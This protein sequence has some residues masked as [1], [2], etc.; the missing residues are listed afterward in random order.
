M[1]DDLAKM[2]ANLSLTEEE[3]VEWEAL[4]GEWQDV[5]SW[6]QLCVVGKLIAD[7]VS[8]ETIKT[9]L[10]RWWKPLGTLS[11][12]VLGENVFLIEFTDGDDKKWILE[13][14][15]WVFEGSLFLIVDFDGHSSPAN[16]TF[17]KAAFWV[18]MKNL[19]LACIGKE[20]GRMLGASAGEVEVVDTDGKGVGWGEYLRVKI[21]MDLSKPLAWGRMLKLQGKTSWIPFQYERLPKFCFHC[22]VI[23]HGQM[24]CPGR[25][26]LRQKESST[27]FGPWL[28][29]PSP[30]RRQERGLGRFGRRKG[31]SDF[32]S[33]GT[34][35]YQ[36]SLGGGTDLN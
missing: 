25:S 12:K 3:C 33:E 34:K 5:S 16:F 24:G 28:R 10:M 11:F 32:G 36:S 23:M 2:W 15:P 26:N 14:R 6:G 21:W 29:A 27:E 9:T 35:G 22:G 20:T 7:F 31:T 17:D 1:A 30:P 8:K 19:P 4:V 18:R 13:G